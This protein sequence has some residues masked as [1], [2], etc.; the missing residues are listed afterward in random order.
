LSFEYHIYAAKLGHASGRMVM[1]T[2][3]QAASFVPAA[4]AAA[5][6]SLGHPDEKA[7]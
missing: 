4:V 5:R 6:H 3:A 2:P 7:G 1:M